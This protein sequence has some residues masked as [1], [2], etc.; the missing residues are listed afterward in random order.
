MRNFN[1][2]KC[3]YCEKDIDTSKAVKE[4]K[5]EYVRTLKNNNFFHK[6]CWEEYNEHLK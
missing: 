2:E 4:K 6:K 3:A 1:I 5:H